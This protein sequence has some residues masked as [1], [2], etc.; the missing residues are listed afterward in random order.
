M[1]AMESGSARGEGGSTTTTSPVDRSWWEE[2]PDERRGQGTLR[3]HPGR[4]PNGSQDDAN[5]PRLDNHRRTSPRSPG[6]AVVAR[7]PPLPDRCRLQPLRR[8]TPLRD[9]GA[10]S[11]RLAAGWPGW[12][13]ALADGPVLVARRHRWVPGGGSDVYRCWT[14]RPHGV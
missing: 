12:V 6:V 9:L 4:W 3:V 7:R 1:T 5:P 10:V 8:G 14:R 13:E 11:P 2:G